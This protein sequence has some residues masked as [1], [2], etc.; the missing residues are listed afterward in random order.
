MAL[1]SLERTTP[2]WLN[3]P[4]MMRLTITTY[5]VLEMIGEWE[6]VRPYNFLLLPMVDPTFGYAFDRRPNEKVLLIAPFSSKQERWFGLECTNIHSGKKYKMVDCTAELSPTHNVVFPSQF[7]RLMIEYQEHPEAK[8]LAP[9]GEPCGAA[10]SGLLKRTH[11]IAGEFRYVGKETDRK[12]EEGDDLS[13]LE[14]KA[15]EYGRA[16]KVAADTDLA[17]EI[18]AIGIRKTMEL[19][20]MSQH[21]IEKLIHDKAVKRKTHEHVLNAIQGYRSVT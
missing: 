20:K 14:F 13:V 11:V 12:W 19:T 4:Q 1:S 18:R 2:S 7:S 6:I 9:D 10:T 5:N 16:K 21:T 17:D 3:L 15:T 8:S